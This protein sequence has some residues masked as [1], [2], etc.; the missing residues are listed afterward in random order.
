MKGGENIIKK[1]KILYIVS[2]LKKCGPINIL[3]NLTKYIDKEI[4]EI[5]IVSLSKECENTRKEE[6]E[7]LGCKTYNL[8]L[9]K[10]NAIFSSKKLILNIIKE[11]NIDIIH[12]HG[13]RADL[14]NTK[15]R[16]YKTVSTL[17]NYPFED[18]KMYYGKIKGFLIAK[19]HI[20][21]LKKINKV[22]AC[23]K[24][25]KEMLSYKNINFDYVQN[26]VDY[27]V[28]TIS[29]DEEKYE[30]RKELNLPQ[31]KK[32]YIVV[33]EISYGKNVSTIINCFNNRK[34]N[35]EILLIIGNGKLYSRSIALSKDNENILFKGKVDNVDK[36][37]KSSDYYIS[38]SLSEG[39]PNSV[40]EAMSTGIPCIL[41][42]IKPHEEIINNHNQLF[43]SK[44]I[45]N[46][47]ETINHVINEDYQYLKKESRLTIENNLSA[48]NMAINYELK[49]RALF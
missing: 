27:E 42:K 40:L 29:K 6:F 2:N 37:L 5:F 12:S 10:I 7:S 15:L 28:F 35:N 33:G 21:I 11:N 1:I 16:K 24:S 23:S 47:S 31:N 46:L 34:N 39:L 3:Y 22:F 45:N 36:Y 26:G 9:K 19:F 25:V 49:Y 44:D 41:S 4:Y 20:S 8:N 43:I 17:H 30:I 14:I 18:Y 32:I 38:A 13:I 48:K